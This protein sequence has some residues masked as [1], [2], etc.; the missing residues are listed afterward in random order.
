MSEKIPIFEESSV[1]QEKDP[2]ELRRVLDRSI[3]YGTTEE[4]MSLFENGMDINQVDFQDRTALQMMSFKGK[5]DVVEKLISMGAN[6]NHV[7]MFQD[8]IPMTALDAAQQASRTEIVS[9]LLH[10]GAKTGKE[11]MSN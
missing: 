7:F 11:M 1:P 8:R 6:I 9:I 10:H 3:E 2:N 5:K 4:L